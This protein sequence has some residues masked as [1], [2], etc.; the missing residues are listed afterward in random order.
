MNEFDHLDDFDDFEAMYLS[1]AAYGPEETDFTTT[2]DFHELSDE[3]KLWVAQVVSNYT[4]GLEE[5]GLQMLPQEPEDILAKHKAYVE[6][7]HKLNYQDCTHTKMVLGFIA[8]TSPEAHNGQDH[9]EV[10]TL[11]VAKKWRRQGMAEHLTGIVTGALVQDG[12]V[13]FA[14]VNPLSMPIFVSDG[15]VPAKLSQLP[16]S[17]FDACA[18]CP[19]KPVEGCCDVQLIKEIGNGQ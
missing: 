7:G 11:Y 18:T 17:V 10:G 12:T 16:P 9:S 15:Y 4:K 3:E 2:H 5:K 1:H 8:A 6:M 13:P 14:F 19:K